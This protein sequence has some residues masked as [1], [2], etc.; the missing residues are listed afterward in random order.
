MY[1]HV[2]VYM[3]STCRYVRTVHAYYTYHMHHSLTS[4]ALSCLLVS[5]ILCWALSRTDI[6]VSCLPPLSP[7]PLPWLGGGGREGEEV[8]ALLG[9]D[10]LSSS[11]WSRKRAHVALREAVGIRV[12]QYYNVYIQSCTRCVYLRSNL[13]V[14]VP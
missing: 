7:G 13:P 5:S 9:R 6:A 2:H 12:D 3:Y 10:F 4:M 1:I 8:G 11:L 14:L